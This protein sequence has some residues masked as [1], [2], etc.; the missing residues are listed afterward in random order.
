MLAAL[1]LQCFESVIMCNMLKKEYQANEH[2]DLTT[3]KNLSSGYI[4]SFNSHSSG[5]TN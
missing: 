3:A 5:L 4:E 2:F 1:T